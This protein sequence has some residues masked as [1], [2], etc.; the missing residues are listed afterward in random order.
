MNLFYDWHLLPENRYI[1]H[2]K[3]KGYYHISSH[4]LEKNVIFKKKEDFIAGMNDI[5]ICVLGFDVIILCFCLMSNHFHFV[6]YGTLP[7][8][9]RFSE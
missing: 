3:M 1:L 5:A 9:R 8:C 4:G 6:L 7:E 2:Q